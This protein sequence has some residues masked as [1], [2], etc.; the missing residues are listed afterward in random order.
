MSKPFFVDVDCFHCQ[1][2]SQRVCGDYF[3]SQ[4]IPSEGRLVATLSDGLGSGVKAN[5][6][7]AM[8]ATMTVRFAVAER[9]VLRSAEVVMDSLPICQTRQIS[10]ATFSIVDCNDAGDA[11]IVEEGNPPFLLVRDGREFAV[12]KKTLVSTKRPNRKLQV[13]SFRLEPGDRVIFCSDGV[14]QAGL[15]GETWRLGW[16]RS[17]LVS[18]VLKTLAE[19]PEMSSRTLS[20]A[21]VDEA[22]RKEPNGVANDD[23]SAAVFYFRKPRR[24]LLWS[25]PPFSRER[26]REYAEKFAAFPGKK[27]IAGGTTANVAA[28]EL[29]RPITMKSSRE[30]SSV[31]FASEMLD[32]DLVTEGV[33]T[34]AQTLEYLEEDVR[35]TLPDAASA[36]ADLLL[37]ADEIELMIGTRVNEA[38]LDPTLPTSLAFRRNLTDR[39]TKILKERYL[40]DVETVYV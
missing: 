9:D 32:V 33:L 5:I 2:R 30:R 20:R 23:V 19:T 12:E 27:A 38:H 8:T 13:A 28:R 14:T 16:R 34:L 29:R 39:L 35:P 25:G 17:G 3:V 36:L 6:L 15:G 22:I 11:T 10:Y 7:A 4:R 18:F 1:K 40:K 24:L 26:D 37:D 31:P 21:I